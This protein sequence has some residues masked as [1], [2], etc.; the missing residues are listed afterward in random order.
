[1]KCL[2][3][4]TLINANIKATTEKGG[5]SV[6]LSQELIEKLSDYVEKIGNMLGWNTIEKICLAAYQVIKNHPFI[7]GNKRTAFYIILKCLKS[8]NKTF[9]GRH[10]D[11]AYKIVD[12]A[13]SNSTEKEIK[14]L[15]LA[16]FLKRHLKGSAEGD[17]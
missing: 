12:I 14:I 15:E 4:N 2:D 10:K 11:L 9:T 6:V 1:M 13:K 16:Y 17:T 8:I 3:F 7:D 5:I